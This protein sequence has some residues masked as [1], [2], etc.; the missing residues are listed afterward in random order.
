[1]K[2]VSK[3]ASFKMLCLAL[4]AC[5]AGAAMAVI[6][7]GEV[8][9][10]TTPQTFTGACC[11]SWFETVRVTEPATPAP[12]VVTWSVDYNIGGEFVGLS[13]NSGPCQFYGPRSMYST[14]S[15]EPPGPVQSRTFNW[16]VLP[17]DGPPANALHKGTNTFTLC[18]GGMTSAAHQINLFNNTLSVRISQ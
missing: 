14:F 16:I 7:G 5:V 1:M 4:F 12:V 9:R 8:L 3:S 11:F 15:V 17:S 2:V 10:I 18:G 6:P 13:V